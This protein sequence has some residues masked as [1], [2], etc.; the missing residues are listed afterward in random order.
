[1]V[2]LCVNRCECFHLASAHAASRDLSN[3]GIPL[4][5]CAFYHCFNCLIFDHDFVRRESGYFGSFASFGGHPGLFLAPF[6]KKENPP[7]K[8]ISHRGANREFPENTLAAFE[9]ALEI[10]V[11]GLETDLQVTRDD[12]LVLCHDDEILEQR[13][14]R[15]IKSLSLTELKEIDVGRGHSVATFDE[16]LNRFSGKA[17]LLLD[18]K[19]QGAGVI[20]AQRLKN[21]KH[22][23]QIHIS[24]F[25]EE[26]ILAVK[27]IIPAISLA[28]IFSAVPP[29]VA[30][31]CAGLGI[32]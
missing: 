10:G 9:R 28:M 7:L 16:F 22:L 18:V 12:E 30:A 14:R 23:D 4:G 27:K 31:R 29:D 3:D 5:S 11:D 6:R 15:R 25:Y 17:A 32:R 8:I 2:F 21:Q 13:K 26:E 19:S 20:L 24:S 1:M